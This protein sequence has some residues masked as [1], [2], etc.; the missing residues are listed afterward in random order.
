[1]MMV[2]MVMV[3][4]VMMMMVKKKRNGPFSDLL[5]TKIAHMNKQTAK[6]QR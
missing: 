3:M 5:S 4:M 2:V 1:M 6:K